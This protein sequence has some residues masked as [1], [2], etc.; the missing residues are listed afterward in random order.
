MIVYFSKSY[1][2][3]GHKNASNFLPTSSIY[4]KK[5]VVSQYFSL[6]TGNLVSDKAVIFT[7]DQFF[8]FDLNIIKKS[9][10]FAFFVLL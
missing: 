6:L 7:K 8:I 1:I 2:F 10:L 5:L 3:I 4:K 9:Q